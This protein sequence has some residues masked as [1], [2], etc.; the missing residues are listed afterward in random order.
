MALWGGDG[1][2]RTIRFLEPTE[3]TL[4]TER[5]R[6]PPWGLGTAQSGQV[7]RNSL[8][9]RE[10]PGKCHLHVDTGQELTIETPGG[11]GFGPAASDDDSG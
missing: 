6:H 1:L 7:G 9:D 10:L 3:V 2:L 5:R 8:D 11:G 4:L